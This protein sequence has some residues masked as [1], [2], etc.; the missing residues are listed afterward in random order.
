[1]IRELTEEEKKICLKN[2][3]FI[4]EELKEAIENLDIM[5]KHQVFLEIKRKYEDEL[6]PVNRKSEDKQIND[7]IKELKSIIKFKE[8]VLT[9]LNKQINEGVESKEEIPI[10]VY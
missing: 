1:M 10:G 6:R 8:E 4:E 9:G 7:K 5:E 3:S 2:K